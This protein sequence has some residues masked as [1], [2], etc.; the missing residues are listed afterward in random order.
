MKYILYSTFTINY[1]K[2]T[3][4]NCLKMKYLIVVVCFQF[5]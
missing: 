5:N 3:F 4:N 1:L 2:C